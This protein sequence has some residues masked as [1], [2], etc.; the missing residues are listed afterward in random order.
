[1]PKFYRSVYS[2]VAN[3]PASV[4]REESKKE[5]NTAKNASEREIKRN[6][7]TSARFFFLFFGILDRSRDCSY[8]P[9]VSARKNVGVTRRA[10]AKRFLRKG[11]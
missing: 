2:S 4:L 7:I 5:G 11:E 3:I 10:Y 6:S 8:R 9:S 1:M